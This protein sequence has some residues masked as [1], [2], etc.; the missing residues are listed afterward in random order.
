M[1]ENAP[2]EN[3]ESHIEQWKIK[4][5]I[6]KLSTARG[7]GTSFVS[8]YI[9]AGDPLVKHMQLL[10]SELSGAESIKSRQT[11]QSVQAAITSSREKLKLYKNTPENGLCIFCGI[12]LMEDGKSEKKITIALEPYRPINVFA[13]KCQNSFY[14]E[15]LLSLLSDDDK[16]GFIIIDGNGILF[17]TL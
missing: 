13:Y 3:D 1:V 14:T 17:A 6:K 10:A 11:R 2:I 15:P 12:I 8:L 5:L 16:F 4:R 9:P 7:N